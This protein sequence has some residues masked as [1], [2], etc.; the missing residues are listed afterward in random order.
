MFSHGPLFSYGHL[1]SMGCFEL[2]RDLISSNLNLTCD[3]GTSI[4]FDTEILN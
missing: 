2:F 3:R 1:H 4:K